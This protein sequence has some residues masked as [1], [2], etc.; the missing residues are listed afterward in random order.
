MLRLD[1]KLGE[2]WCFSPLMLLWG[3]FQEISIATL[4]LGLKLLHVEKFRKCRL[5]DVRE[6]ELKDEKEETILLCAKDRFRRTGDLINRGS[7]KNR[8]E[9][10]RVE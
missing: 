2:I 7:D 6:S 10:S 3:H 5:T 9:K 1:A 8:V 4:P